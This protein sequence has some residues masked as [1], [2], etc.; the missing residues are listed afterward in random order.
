M[1]QPK[2]RI[3]KSVPESIIHSHQ[4]WGNGTT[5][6]ALGYAIFLAW[7][8]FAVFGV[9][10]RMSDESLGR[11]YF[12]RDIGGLNPECKISGQKVTAIFGCVKTDTG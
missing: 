3:A 11:S 8:A 5:C 6:R 10:M 1:V 4:N 7:V 2:L 9:L 12:I